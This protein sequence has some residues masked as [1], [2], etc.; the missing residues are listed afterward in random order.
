MIYENEIHRVREVDFAPSSSIEQ[1]SDI[2]LE[3][4]S[5][6]HIPKALKDFCYYKESPVQFTLVPGS[7]FSCNSDLVPMTHGKKKDKK[8]KRKR[9]ASINQVNKDAVNCFF[10]KNKGHMKKACP[11]YKTWVVKER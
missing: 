3:L 10:C 5:R 7:V 2:C 9:K 8:R 11:K 6:A 4:P 1:S